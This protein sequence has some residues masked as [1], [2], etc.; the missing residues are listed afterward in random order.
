MSSQHHEPDRATRGQHVVSRADPRV[1]LIAD[2]GARAIAE[3]QSL[4]SKLASAESALSAST[5]VADK[6]RNARQVAQEQLDGVLHAVREASEGESR[7][8]RLVKKLDEEG[9]RCAS[10]SSVARLVARN[11]RRADVRLPVRGDGTDGAR[12]TRSVRR[13]ER[14]RA[15]AGGAQYDGSC[16]SVS[17]GDR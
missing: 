13:S 12:S 17:S 16:R 3:A 5:R 8:E 2:E 6:E 1:V 15:R 4:R 7:L 10:L 9:G 14:A 11:Y